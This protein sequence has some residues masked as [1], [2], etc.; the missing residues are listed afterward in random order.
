MAVLALVYACGLAD[1]GILTSA[2]T[3][4]AGQYQGTIQYTLPYVTANVDYCVFKPGLFPFTPANNLVIP[5]DHYVYA[6]QILSLTPGAIPSW[7][8]ASRLSVGLDGN[9]QVGV[10]G[11]AMEDNSPPPGQLAPSLYQ[12]ANGSLAVGWTFSPALSATSSPV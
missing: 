7:A 12:V 2:N 10:V 5:A 4:M 1:A 3:G 8:Y 9:E 6:Y 11:Y